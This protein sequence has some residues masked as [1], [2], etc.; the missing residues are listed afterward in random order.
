MCKTPSDID[1]ILNSVYE[2]PEANTSAISQLLLLEDSADIERLFSFANKIRR[3]FMGDG[4]ILR[5]LVEFSNIC[6]N[7]CFYCGLNAQNTSI[8]RYRMSS[9]EI[10]EAVR[11]I[12]LFKIGT[13]V[14]QSGEDAALDPLWFADIIRKIKNNYNIAVT[15]SAGEKYGDEY[16]LWKDAG[17]D[18]YL[19]KIETTDTDVYSAAHNGRQLASRLRC[20]DILQSLGYQT[21]SGILIGLRGQTID[22]LANDV[23]FL[24][25][26]DFDMIGIGPF[27]P[28]P[29]TAFADNMPGSVLLTLK[30]LAVVR[31][32]TRDSHMP[33]TTALGSADSDYRIDGLNAGAN[34]VMP[35]F[36]PEK[37]RALYQIYPGK[38]CLQEPPEKGIACVCEK[39][40]STGRFIDY[41]TGHSIKKHFLR[42]NRTE[43]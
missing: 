26:R 23:L 32:A 13:V 35:N 28:H 4:I 12:S 6:G 24:K 5:G 31:I 42:D 7:S 10:L 14:L 2:N 8:K 15:I 3:K 33:A 17:A 38:V 43:Q 20:L 36:T 34:V 11:K 16:K 9:E 30:M 39:A 22:S 18:R 19:L 25:R 21:G 41:S 40:E 37:Y 27:I 29:H 1:D